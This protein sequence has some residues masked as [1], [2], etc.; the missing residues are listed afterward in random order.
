MDNWIL[1]HLDADAPDFP[2]ARTKSLDKPH[3]NTS[4]S[5]DRIFPNAIRVNKNEF[6]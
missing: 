3:P 2:D 4:G 6:I 1:P 5:I